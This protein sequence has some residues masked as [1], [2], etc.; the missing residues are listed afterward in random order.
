MIEYLSPSS[1][2]AFFDDPRNFYL[3]RLATTRIA[4]MPQTEPMAVGSSFDAYVKAY[5]H[6]KCFGHSG[7]DGSFDLSALL[8][9]QIETTDAAMRARVEAAGSYLFDVYVSSGALASLMTEISCGY[10]ISFEKTISGRVRSVPMLGKPDMKMQIG[11]QRSMLSAGSCVYI[12]DWKVNGFMAKKAPSPKKH[13]LRCGAEKRYK[14]VSTAT[15][16]GIEY[17]TGVCLSEIDESWAAQTCTYAWLLGAPV[18]GEILC[19]IDQL[20]GGV[21]AVRVAS[22][23]ALV[24]PAYQERLMAR[25]EAAWGLLSDEGRLRRYYQTIGI[26]VDELEREAATLGAPGGEFLRTL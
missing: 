17:V 9:G 10:A 6:K 2:K 18:G 19:G 26:D 23:R 8:A 12:L 14:G 11:P 15:L 7:A 13:Y 22:F 25:Y 1:L 24:S 20:V 4:R 3:E 5:L 21:G 16:H